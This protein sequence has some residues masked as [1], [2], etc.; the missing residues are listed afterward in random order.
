[1]FLTGILVF[2][3]IHGFNFYISWVCFVGPATILA[4]ALGVIFWHLSTL[5]KQVNGIF[6]ND[7]LLF[8]HYLAFFV[9]TACD[10]VAM[11]I[12][13]F[14]TKAYH[15]SHEHQTSE[16][17]KLDIAMDV[18]SV[19]QSLAWFVCQIIMIYVFFKY[20]RPVERDSMRIFRRKMEM[21]YESKTDPQAKIKRHLK[22]VDEMV[23]RQIEDIMRT[24]T[25][26]NTRG[27][28]THLQSEELDENG[29]LPRTSPQ[30]EA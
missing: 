5:N 25:S 28:G 18:M 30:S 12:Q 4:I 20:G 1:M 3:I 9:A 13:T 27:R 23:D 19:L 10:G 6:C 11:I 16:Q 26:Y 2:Q 24:M 29:C 7:R 14:D 21:I 17:L 22:A 8:V 15:K